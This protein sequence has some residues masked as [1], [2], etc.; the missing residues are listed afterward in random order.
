[1]LVTQGLEG[2]GEEDLIEKA[3]EFSIDVDEFKD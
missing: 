2:W 1:M 3:A